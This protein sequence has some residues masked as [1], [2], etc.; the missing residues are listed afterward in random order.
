MAATA[1][2]QVAAL[3]GGPKVFGPAF[4]AADFVTAVRQGLPFAALEALT[5]ALQLD[6]HAIGSA[7]GI[8][9]RTLARRKHEKQLSPLESDRLYRI[10]FVLS[11]AASTLGEVDKARTWLH[12]SN[13]A[14]G[15]T[16]PLSMLDTEIGARKVEQTLLQMTHGIYA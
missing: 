16:T 12:R 11:L 6:L 2:T 7:L 15:G 4:K 14:L 10:A 3:L 9:P 1:E 13:R 5:S 8:A